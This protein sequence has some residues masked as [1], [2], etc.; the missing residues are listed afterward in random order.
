MPKESPLDYD[1]GNGPK[2]RICRFFHVDTSALVA[3]ALENED[4]SMVLERYFTNG[5]RP[6]DEGFFVF[7]AFLSKRGWQDDESEWSRTQKEQMSLS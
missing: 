2:G 3:N 7:N 4:G 6:T 1:R 5:R